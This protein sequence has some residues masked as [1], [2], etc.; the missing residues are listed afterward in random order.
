M[1]YRKLAIVVELS[2]DNYERVVR[3]VVV[4]SRKFMLFTIRHIKSLNRD[5]DKFEY[6]GIGKTSRFGSWVSNQHDI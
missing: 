6:Y 2:A 1:I 3:A 5:D 4:I